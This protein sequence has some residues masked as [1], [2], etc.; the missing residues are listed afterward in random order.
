MTIL[1]TGGAGYIGSHTCIELLNAKY[2]VVVIDNLSNGDIDS[3]R[4]V[5]NITK[6]KLITDGSI[7]KNNVFIFE[8]IDIRNRSELARIFSK[9]SIECVIHFAGLKAVGE[10]VDKPLYYYDNNVSGSL[11]LYGE[12]KSAGVNKIVFSS[13]ATVYADHA[14]L[15]CDH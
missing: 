10:S 11:A 14:S 12:M 8:K 2:K 7:D 1:V 5:A 3:L 13:S 9:Y 6:T 15:V 4:Q